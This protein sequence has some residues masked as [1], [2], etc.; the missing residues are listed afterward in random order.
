[1]LH[2]LYGQAMKHDIQFFGACPSRCHVWDGPARLRQTPALS[3]SPGPACPLA[4]CCAKHLACELQH[5]KRLAHGAMP[6]SLLPAVEYFAMDLMM[7]K[8]GSCKGVTALC[9]EDGTIHRF[10][11]RWCLF[12]RPCECVPC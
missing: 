5:L 7:D 2:T 12:R 9:M 4:D 10:Q 6:G 3:T 1:M 8:D 11:V